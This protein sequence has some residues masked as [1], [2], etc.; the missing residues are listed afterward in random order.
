[1]KVSFV[2][3]LTNN[4]SLIKMKAAGYTTIYLCRA[5]FTHLFQQVVCNDSTHRLALCVELDFQVFAVST[6][7]VVAKGF[8]TAKTLQQGICCQD[9]FLDFLDGWILSIARNSSNVL[10]DSLGC[11]CLTGTRL[12]TDDDTLVLLV[13]VHMVV[14]WFSNSKNM[15]GHLNIV[16]VSVPVCVLI[17]GSMHYLQQVLSSIAGQHILCVDAQISERIDTDEYMPNIRLCIWIWDTV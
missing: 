12:T 4:T 8:C 13:A 3:N 9:H 17:S 5:S 1:M 6:R 15:R 11:L 14:G 7:V 16:L 2:F 10:H